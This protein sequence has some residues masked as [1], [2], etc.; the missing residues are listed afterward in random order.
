MVVS[1]SVVNPETTVTPPGPPPMVGLYTST[2]P[3]KRIISEV[4]IAG[5]NDGKSEAAIVVIAMAAIP[6][7]A[8]FRRNCD[9]WTA[10]NADIPVN[11]APTISVFEKFVAVDIV[12]FERFTLDKST[13][14]RSDAVRLHAGP[15]INPPRSWKFAGRVTAAAVAAAG[16]TICPERIPARVA[17]VKLAPEIS[18]AVRMAFV[19]FVLVKSALVSVVFERLTDVRFLFERMTLGPTMNPPRMV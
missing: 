17:P 5:F 2:P 6:T 19:R 16:E 12:V 3:V 9:F 7:F 4:R 10:V 8:A 13:S 18:A 11:V 1:A 15:T 14:V